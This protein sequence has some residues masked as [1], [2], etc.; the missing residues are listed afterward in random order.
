[1][2]LKQVLPL[3]FSR[4]HF[5]VKRKVDRTY[6]HQGT[7][8]LLEMAKQ[9]GVVGVAMS[10]KKKDE[11]I[12]ILVE[13]LVTMRPDEMP[14]QVID[15]LPKEPWQGIQGKDKKILTELAQ[16]TAGKSK[17]EL[18]TSFL[19]FPKSFL[20]LVHQLIEHNLFPDETKNVVWIGNDLTSITFLNRSNILRVLNRRDRS[21][22]VLPQEFFDADQPQYDVMDGSTGALVTGTAMAAAVSQST[23]RRRRKAASLMTTTTTATDGAAATSNKNGSGGGGS[24]LDTNRIL[25]ATLNALG[26]QEKASKHSSAETA[27]YWK[28]REAVERENAKRAKMDTEVRRFEILQEILPTLDSETRLQMNEE[29]QH[30]KAAFCRTLL[31]AGEQANSKPPAKEAGGATYEGEVE[32]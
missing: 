3:V 4:K 26:R 19:S 31:Q 11:M 6:R 12:Q 1:M 28:Y 18:L 7:V 2:F 8:F 14:Q 20:E 10:E 21:T 22:W 5:H 32:V 23:V 30:Q 25:T 24:T 9:M 13:R 15:N 27:Q 16:L 17:D 29:L